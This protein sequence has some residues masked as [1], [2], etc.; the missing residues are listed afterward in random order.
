MCSLALKGCDTSV[1]CQSLAAPDIRD[2]ERGLMSISRSSEPP[3]GDCNPTGDIT[4]R[5][6]YCRELYGWAH[7]HEHEGSQSRTSGD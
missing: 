3:D 2:Q 1:K 4:D 6:G 7:A 5:R